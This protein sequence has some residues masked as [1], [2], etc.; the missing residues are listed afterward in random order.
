VD[1]DA[2]VRPPE[3][4]HQ[5]RLARGHPQRLCSA[6]VEQ[7]SAS[8]YHQEAE[9]IRRE[10]ETMTNA[11]VRDG[12]RE[13]ARQY[14]MLADD[15][16]GATCAVPA[17]AAERLLSVQLRDPRQVAPATGGERRRIAAIARARDSV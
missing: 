13:I 5:H 17:A 1:R 14:D 6:A 12:L 7:D 15:A 16:F 8:H 3:R 11:S 2:A 9:R 4:P 10:A